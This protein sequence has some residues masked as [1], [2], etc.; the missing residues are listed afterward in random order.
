MQTEITTRH[1]TLGD[2]QRE[3]I[4]ETLAKLERFSPRPVLS[5]RLTITHEAGRFAADAVLRLKNNDFRAEAAAVEPEYAADEIVESLRKQLT[6]FKGRISGKQKG[7]EGGLGRAMVD[8]GG[9]F[10]ATDAAAPDEGGAEGFVLRAMDLAGAQA[11]FATADL[12]FL[13]FRDVETSRLGVIY[14]RGDGELG[15]ME[16]HED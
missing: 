9:V 16:A 3:K 1:F 13:I 6:K 2:D 14:R 8:D 4:E 5:C 10:A 11:A 7:E 12:P 15:H